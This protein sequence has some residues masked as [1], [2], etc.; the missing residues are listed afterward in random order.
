MTSKNF[1]DR[2]NAVCKK[3]QE[4]MAIFLESERKQ[5]EKNCALV[6]LPIDCSDED[7][8]MALESYYARG[9]SDLDYAG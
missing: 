8:R 7:L 6:G 4:K 9:T 3:H 2:F 1:L 5:R